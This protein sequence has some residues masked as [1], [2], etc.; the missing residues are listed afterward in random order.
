MRTPRPSRRQFLGGAAAGAVAS[1]LPVTAQEKA[2]HR[3]DTFSLAPAKWIWLPGQRTLPNTFVLFRRELTLDAAPAR[4]A[5]WIAADSRYRLT[6]N[7]TRVQWGPAPCDPRELDVDPFDITALLG[8]GQNVI[9]VEV[10]FYGYG[11]GTWP[12]G[13][14]G[15]LFQAAIDSTTVVSDER[16]LALVDRAHPPGAAKRWFLRA[17]Q[18]QYDA[19]LRPEGWDSAGFVP[20]ER[21][22][23]AQ[24]LACPANK[25]AACATGRYWSN[26]SVDQ[27]NPAVAS[28][29]PRE[30]PAVRETEVPAAR[31]ADSGRVEW[32]RNPD[33]WFDFRIPGSFRIARDAAA[34][35]EL[36]AAP[37]G[38][39]V[40][41]TFEFKEQLVGWPYFSIDAPAGAIVELM[42]Q[43]SHDPAGT[44]WLDTHHFSWSRFVCREGANRFEAFDYESLRWLQLHVRNAAR[45]VRISGV[46]VRRR[47]FAWPHAPHIRCSDR[48]LQRVFDAAINTIQNAAIE[49]IMDGVGRERQQYSG[50]LGHLLHA[51]RYAFGEERVARRYLRTF[52]SGLS[53]E[54]FF[55]DCWP[56]YDRL[57]RVAQREVDAAFWGPLVDHG[58][59]FNFDCWNH[60]LETGDRAALAEPYPRLVRFAEYLE[61]LRRADELLPVENLG[62]ANV[63]MDTDAYRRQRHKQCA[64][65][66]YAAAMLRHALAPLAGLFGDGGRAAHYRQTSDA[67]LAAAV[68]QFWDQD[69]GLFVI[70]R[71]WLAEEKEP[72]LCDRSLATAILFDQ[73]P[74]GRTA[75][76]VNALVSCPPEMGFS[77]PANAG[78]RFWALARAGRIDVV[79]GDLR[80]RWAALPSVR[81]NNT[82]QEAWRVSPDSTDEWSH[83][84]VAPLYVLFMDVAGLRP[85]APGFTRCRI[86]PQLGDLEDL[87]LTAWTPRGPIEFQARGHRV[88][89]ALPPGCEGEFEGRP[90]AAGR[91]HE[92]TLSR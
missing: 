82:L 21:W 19:R 22:V 84:P 64:F 10:L 20:D 88:R 30:I 35:A 6:V 87:E 68:R 25:P 4:A 15:L 63:W 8:P 14:P 13:R 74:G 5:G 50:D 78:W 45:P 44:P 11:E 42:T 69:R 26:D 40:Y 53:K 49:T 89:V 56:A 31:L 38:Q 39:G 75:A 92:L 23:A 3:A 33:D 47:T 9:G 62:V 2:P 60:Y 32:L 80:T 91:A 29:R 77:Y 61:S 72:R 83:C 65:N 70:N 52:S 34:T 43:E 36:P 37:P 76:A 46:G 73:C 66:L 85:A 48:D 71:P 27:V 18:E 58:I 51:V 57:A 79:L 67:L 16:W 86:A 12:G 81:L 7:G 90:L 1:T 54:G 28:L 55:L 41:A 24:P 59:Q 17:L